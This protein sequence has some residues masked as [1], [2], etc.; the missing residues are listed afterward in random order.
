MRHQGYLKDRAALMAAVTLISVL[1]LGGAGG[2]WLGRHT[3]KSSS[4]TSAPPH[5]GLPHEGLG[6]TPGQLRRA[7]E[8]GDR[9]RGRLEAIRRR[10]APDA[11][12]IHRKMREEFRR[13]LTP[14]QRKL[15]DARFPGVGQGM[16][17][18]TPG[19]GRSPGG[20]GTEDLFPRRPPPQALKACL[21]KS[22]AALCH[23][24]GLRG[25]DVQGFCR[26]PPRHK[27]L[28][29]IPARRPGPPVTP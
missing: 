23:F 14:A 24:S 10:I 15:H 22:E 6:L 2:F 20:M 18:K 3:S 19:T 1:L 28:A 26:R 29:C 4:G 25:K 11:E 7:R 8:I 13:I 12:A 9:Y 27:G 17:H 21:G 5:Q 16:E